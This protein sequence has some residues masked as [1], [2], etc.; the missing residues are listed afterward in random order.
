M[1]VSYFVVCFAK[2]NPS[3]YLWN[4]KYDKCIAG[5]T[6]YYSSQICS[7][8]AMWI[9]ACQS[10]HVTLMCYIPLKPRIHE[11]AERFANH[12][13]TVHK[14]NA[15]MCGWNCKPALCHPQ[16]VLHTVCREPKFVDCFR[17]HKENWI[18]WVSFPCTGCPLPPPQVGGKLINHTPHVNGAACKRRTRVYKALCDGKILIWAEPG[19]RYRVMHWC[20]AVTVTVYLSTL[21]RN[22]VILQCVMLHVCTH[23]QNYL[24]I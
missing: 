8:N 9:F 12:L 1:G 23:L 11:H 19:W 16:T 4:A 6:L 20:G 7:L 10:T 13:R 17:K 2:K 3:E 21:V 5:L 15:R 22:S 18:L 24:H 14:P